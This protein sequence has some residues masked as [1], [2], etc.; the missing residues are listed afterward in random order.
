MV[1]IISAGTAVYFRPPGHQ[2]PHLWLVLTDPI[3]GDA[4]VV[5]VMVRTRRSFTDDTVILQPADHAF[6]SVE[7]CV[8]YSTAT[9]FTVGRIVSSLGRGTCKL[10]QTVSS[11]LLEAARAGLLLSPRTPNAIKD[12]YRSLSP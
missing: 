9:F 1:N 7:S 6:L 3:D 12:Y 10:M 2:K 8:D 5:A 4:K 11:R